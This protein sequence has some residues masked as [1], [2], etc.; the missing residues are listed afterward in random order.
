MTSAVRDTIIIYDGECRL[1][2]V[3][4]TWPQLL[5]IYYTLAEIL[6][7]LGQSRH[8]ENSASAVISGS[9]LIEALTL[10]LERAS[11]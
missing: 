2:R 10:L 11:Q 9:L 5:H 3:S 7:Y 8:R 1:C 6:S 4:I